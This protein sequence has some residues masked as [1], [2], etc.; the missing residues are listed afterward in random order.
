MG[1]SQVEKC[2]WVLRIHFGGFLVRLDSTF[3]LVLHAK[4]VSKVV[5]DFRPVILDLYG[6]LVAVNC[7]VN[8][9]KLVICIAESEVHVRYFS[10]ELEYLQV[11]RNAFINPLQVE[12]S[13]CLAKQSLGLL[14]LSQAL[15]KLELVNV[16]D[17]F[18]QVLDVQAELAERQQS[19][20]M[21]GVQFV[22]LPD[23]LVGTLKVLLIQE[24]QTELCERIHMVR[25]LLQ[26]VLESL[27]LLLWVL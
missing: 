8:P 23:V 10:C 9:L 11:C 5:P 4:S 15:N 14:L 18:I 24:N 25:V 22:G 20:Y 2:G 12:E 27:D 19:R 1:I 21:A 16:F 7:I 17:C 13:V 3:V 6:F 26:D